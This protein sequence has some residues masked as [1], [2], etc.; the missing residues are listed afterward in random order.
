MWFQLWGSTFYQRCG[1]LKIQRR[2]LFHFQ[3]RINVISTLIH[4]NRT[5]LIRL[6]NVGWDVNFFPRK[7]S[8]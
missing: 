6:C 2:I 1:T 3:R 4:G 5:T 7:S 8:L